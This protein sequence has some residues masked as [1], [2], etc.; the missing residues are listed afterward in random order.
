MKGK[1][2]RK[3]EFISLHGYQSSRYHVGSTG[4]MGGSAGGC[5]RSV[6]NS[7]PP[8]MQTD[9]GKRVKVVQVTFAAR[10]SGAKVGS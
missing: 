5:G 6:G 1:R 10:L 9:K 4:N 8:K 7:Q 3:V 2:N